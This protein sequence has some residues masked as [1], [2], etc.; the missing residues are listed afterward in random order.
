MSV[1]VPVW[2]PGFD[3]V[4]KDRPPSAAEVVLL[5]ACRTDGLAWVGEGCPKDTSDPERAV[6]AGLIRFLL[7]GGDEAHRPHPKGVGIH[8]AWIEG[9]LDFR[10][11]E[12]HLDLFLHKC[13]LPERPVFRD[14]RWAGCTFRAVGRRGC[15]LQ[16]VAVEGNVFLDRG[17]HAT[18]TVDLAGSAITG[19]LACDGGRFE[20]PEG[21]A[22][23]A[24]GATVGASVFLRGK[25]H[26]TGEVNLVRAAI[27]GQLACSGGRFER[28]GAWR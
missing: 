2:V 5:A 1:R 9:A 23:T 14:R 28:P 4:M 17:F 26:A 12:T 19:Q 7:L 22:L 11:C 15:E 10:G 21:V 3:E 6:R 8:G 16:R 20:R 24:M 13:L 18:A 27:K 25:F